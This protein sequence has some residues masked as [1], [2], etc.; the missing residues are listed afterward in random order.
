MGVR[1]PLEAIDLLIYLS[2]C[3]VVVICRNPK[4]GIRGVERWY[5]GQSDNEHEDGALKERK[6]AY[7]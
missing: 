7:N 6:R 5:S 3:L 1:S 2:S 4:I